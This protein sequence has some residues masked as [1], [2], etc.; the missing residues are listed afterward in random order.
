LINRAF[1]TLALDAGLDSA[2]MD[3]TERGLMETLYASDALLGRDRFCA[4]YNRAFR[5]GKIGPV[6]DDKPSKAPQPSPVTA[7]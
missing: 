1:L 3:P 6:Q 7:G 5:A 2:I 4:K